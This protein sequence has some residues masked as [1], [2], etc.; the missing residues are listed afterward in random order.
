MKTNHK[1]VLSSIIAVMLLLTTVT[2]C[3]NESQNASIDMGISNSSINDFGMSSS[4]HSEEKAEDEASTSTLE[5]TIISNVKTDEIVEKA[6]EKIQ[7]NLSINWEDYIGDVETFVYGLIANQLGYQYD[8]FSASVELPDGIEVTGIG[9]TDYQE[10]YANDD[11]TKVCFKAGFIACCG[12]E[13]ISKED[14]DSGLVLNNLDYSDDE[15]SFIVGYQSEA[16]TE[17]SVFYNKYIKYGVDDDGQIFYEV[18]DNSAEN[19]DE[20]LG[21]LYSYDDSRYIF[22]LDVGEYK[23]ITGES[24]S[25]QIDFEELQNQINEIIEKQDKNF[26]TVDIES[27]V[28]FAQSSV[29]SY[30]LSLQEETFLG[31][32]VEQ[33]REAA[34]ALD[35]MECYR[36]TNEGLITI[37]LEHST[38]DQVA[39]WLVGTTCVVVIA[40]GLVG[41]V[42]FIECPAL[43][44]ASGAM[45]GVAIETFMQVVINNQKVQDINWTKVAIAAVSGATAGFLGPYIMATTS[46]AATFIVDSTLD[47]LIGAV[48]QTVYAWMD[49]KDGM[50]MAKSFGTGFA[51][52][53][54][55][56]AGFKAAGA[57]IGRV[58][59]KVGP[60]IAKAGKKIFPKL[61]GKTSKLTTAL[62]KKL[63]GMKA[64]ADSS[65]FHSKY[66]SKKLSFRQLERIISNNTDNLKNKSIKS[67]KNVDIYD[68]DGNKITKDALEELFD[69]ADNNTIIGQY[70]IG[71]DIIKIKKENGIVGIVFDET[72]YQSV[73]LP[74]GI[75]YKL[76]S[77]KSKQRTENFEAAATEFKKRWVNNPD[78][79]PDTIMEAMKKKGYSVD[80]IEDIDPKEIVSMVRDTNNGWV[81]HENIDMKTITLAPRA[82]HDKARGGISHMGGFG[83]AKYLK[84]HMGSEFFERFVESAAT[85][86]VIAISE[87]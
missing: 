64:V 14:F 75:K 1:R 47:G 50:E 85:G 56:S 87:G 4:N 80:T 29:D 84:K 5:N 66:I 28:Y 26:A 83:L 34:A 69:K 61:S 53:F 40:A 63:Y 35:P 36:I 12:E 57:V 60:G 86:T 52:G 55:M 65:V 30:L 42:V 82:L 2:G 32:D 23:P 67:L 7:N 10:C 79:I 62:S 45:T 19:Y 9:Y 48:E 73:E 46:G 13:I 37:D 59:N 6:V 31:Y 24:L 70:K 15:T 8:V 22:D 39:Q 76:G 71:D 51:L 41:S 74:E 25:T 20:E 11:G 49:G 44:A 16:F 54:C 81:F 72:K 77:T 68:A 38:K 27:S 17:H 33:L 21:S 58:A 18:L 3:A 78:E 43:S